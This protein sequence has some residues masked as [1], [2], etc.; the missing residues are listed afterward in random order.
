MGVTLFSSFISVAGINTLTE[1]NFEGDMIY[2]ACNSSSQS[3]TEESQGKN[4]K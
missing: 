1:S 2:L 4:S 3:I